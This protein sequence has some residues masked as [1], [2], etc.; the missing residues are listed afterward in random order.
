MEND[1]CANLGDQR[2][3]S[4]MKETMDIVKNCMFIYYQV[5]VIVIVMDIDAEVR[6]L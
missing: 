3:F 1:W 5:G 6:M 2:Y 4:L